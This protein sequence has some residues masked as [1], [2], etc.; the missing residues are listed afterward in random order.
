[1]I[2]LSAIF[3]LLKIVPGNDL[4][5]VLTIT[6]QP[7]DQTDCKGN[8]VTFSIGTQ[9]GAGIL[10]YLWRRKR[11]FEAEFSSFGAKDSIKLP[12]YNVGSGAEAPDQTMYQV[13][14]SDQES[15]L[16]SL[17]ALL[18]VNQITGISPVGV[19][20][21]TINEGENLDFNVLSSGSGPSAVQWIKKYGNSD[22]RDVTDNQTVSGST[23]A[24]L[25]F[26]NISLSDSGVY[27]VRVI[28]PAMNNTKCTETSQITRTIHIKQAIDMEPPFF[29]NI[30]NRNTTCCPDD[31]E[32]AEWDESQGDIQP[33]RTKSYRM[34][35]FN[36][37]FDLSAAHFFDQI[38]PV[39]DL[40][41]HWG[42]FSSVFPFEP[43][44]DEAEN[45][46]DN[47]TGQISLHPEDIDLECTSDESN[48]YRII[49]WLADRAGNL[50]PEINRHIVTLTI[51]PRPEIISRF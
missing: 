13:T 33:E 39:G 6:S 12:V 14:V 45:I 23:T 29:V 37:L 51:S 40:V 4:A 11:P 36:T 46:L 50:T 24:Q 22:W 43:M 32:Q 41:L 49:Y 35:K 1:M 31:L 44:M 19:A 17:P 47:M 38:T 18:S 42:I 21:Y 5:N 30:H 48:T 34:H 25:R 15:I 20:V 8:K 16:T 10:H 7:L 26:T 27:K 9:G 2:L 3:L 28:F